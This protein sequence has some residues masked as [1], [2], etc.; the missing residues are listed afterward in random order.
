MAHLS[1][2]VRPEA[3]LTGLSVRASSIQD[4]VGCTQIADIGYKASAHPKPPGD[5]VEVANSSGQILD[6][7][8][9]HR[10]T[11]GAPLA[12][13]G[14]EAKPTSLGSS[15]GAPPSWATFWGDPPSCSFLLLSTRQP[16][17]L[18]I[19]IYDNYEVHILLI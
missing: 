19:Q 1:D 18:C 4:A 7:T 11:G 5:K 15:G 9:L 13:G 12:S 16:G 10:G 3:T 17:H 8:P 2:L 6:E 14:V